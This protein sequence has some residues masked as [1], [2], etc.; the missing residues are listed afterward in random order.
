[1][2][3]QIKSSIELAM[4]KVAKL[5]KLTKQEI[6]ERQE[7]EYGPLGRSIARGFLTGVLAGTR[8]EAELFEHEGDRG[9]IVRKA[10]SEFLCQAIDLDDEETTGKVL[11]AIEW[12]VH[13]AQLEETAGRLRGIL[14]EYESQKQQGLATIEAAESACLRDLGVSGSAIRINPN[15]NERWRRRR[16]ELQQAFGPKLS[17]IERELTDHLLSRLRERS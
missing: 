12:L 13:D 5:P 16:N 17:G 9:E 11:E 4:E 3:K 15:E 1:M 8:L 2:S 6:R 10:F 14:R 7:K